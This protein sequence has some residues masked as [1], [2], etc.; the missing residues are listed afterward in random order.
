MLPT[1]KLKTNQ[2]DEFNARKRAPITIQYNKQMGSNPRMPVAAILQQVLKRAQSDG[3]YLFR[4]HQGSR[5]D[6]TTWSIYILSHAG[7]EAD[8]F[9]SARNYL[10]HFQLEDGRVCINL[11]HPEAYWPTPLA[12][13]A[14]EG[15]VSHDQ[16][17]NQARRFLLS[18]SGQHW[19][20]NPAHPYKHDPSIKGWPWIDQTHSWVEST[21]MSMIALHST[22]DSNH[23]RLEEST[24]MLLDRQ[25][26]HG[27]WNYGNTE[28]FGKELRP[29]PEDTGAALSALAG[30]V[31]E[32]A[33]HLS[34]SYLLSR[35]RHL[36]TPISLGWS[37]LG[38]NAW[39]RQPNESEYWVQET[40][41]RE[42]DFGVY[43]TPSLCLLMA[44]LIA[45]RGLK[46][47]SSAQP[48]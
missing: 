39:G 26:S 28:V 29:A 32:S 5:P 3:S 2:T 21:A 34:I 20:R 22:G 13:L 23:Q 45:P 35:I 38:L 9:L 15:S 24:N 1:I 11:D 25:L 44:P 14:W 6:A 30:R 36:R 41:S 33:V 18:T 37:L 4:P 19:E 27:G 42:S 12:I 8:A 10:A 31:P 40:F 7:I 17:R 47:L 16:H 43:D 48:A 46:E